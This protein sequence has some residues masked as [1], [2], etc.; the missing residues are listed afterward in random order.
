MT[1]K[2]DYLD[3]GGHQCLEVLG[4]LFWDLIVLVGLLLN[5]NV[6][7][8]DLEFSS[9]GGSGKLESV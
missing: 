6:G 9:F 2:K 3:L 1:V 7:E 4:Y 5:I 8:L